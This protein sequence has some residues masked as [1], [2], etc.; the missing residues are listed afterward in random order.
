MEKEK[1]KEVIN[2]SYKSTSQGFLIDVDWAAT[3]LEAFITDEHTHLT[4]QIKSM[5]NYISDVD[6]QVK[7]LRE[8]L[9]KSTIA[10]NNQA[11]TIRNYQDVYKKHFGYNDMACS[12]NLDQELTQLLSGNKK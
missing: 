1:I 2:N 6:G 5:E 12:E 8:E 3:K 7:E 9:D 10:R 4:D 11:Q